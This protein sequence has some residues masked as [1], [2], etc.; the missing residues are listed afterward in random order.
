MAPGEGPLSGTAISLSRTGASGEADLLRHV[1]RRPPSIPATKC[2]VP[3]AKTPQID[4]QDSVRSINSHCCSGSL[5]GFLEAT[6]ANLQPPAAT[7]P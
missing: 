5:R 4:D 7:F 1:E 2:N 3:L 6:A